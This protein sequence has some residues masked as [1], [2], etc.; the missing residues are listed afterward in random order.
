MIA[1]KYGLN[2]GSQSQTQNE[3]ILFFLQLLLQNTATIRPW[4]QN[5]R[6]NTLLLRQDT[7]RCCRDKE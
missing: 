1:Q 3:L 5:D 6:C 2:M 7:Q 4:L